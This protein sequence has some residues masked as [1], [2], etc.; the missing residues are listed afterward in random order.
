MTGGEP[1]PAERVS[2]RHVREI[3]RLKY[4]RHRANDRPVVGDRAQHSGGKLDHLA[5]S[6]AWLATH[7]RRR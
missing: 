5:G 3:L 7:T 1:M 4:E 2:M 6:G